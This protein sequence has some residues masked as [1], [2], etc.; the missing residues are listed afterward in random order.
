LAPAALVLLLTTSA[1]AQQSRVYLGITLG[2]HHEHTDSLS[3]TGPAIG[4]VGGVRVNRN[5]AIEAEI[6]RP[7]SL[8]VRERTGK[9]VSFATT[10]AD[11]DR[12][13][14]TV[15]TRHT[16]DVTA[17]MSVGAVYQPQVHP[18]V[19]P[20]LF[21]GVSNRSV[22]DR[23]SY[24]ILALPEGVTQEQAARAF[25]PSANSRQ[26]GGVSLGAGVGI[27]LTPH[28]SVAP[29]FRYDYGSIGDHI[30]NAL[31]SSARLAW[32]F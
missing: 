22:R 8:Y 13:A 5:W 27:T 14:P 7:T 24:D 4:A 25:R 28:L 29:E 23:E 1:H 17:A 31:R 21:M 20:R 6:S 19:Q 30:D 2:S 16:R 3:G 18:R 32:S 15:R 12:L 26:M 9:P 10:L 11:F